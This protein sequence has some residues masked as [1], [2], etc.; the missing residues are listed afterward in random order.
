MSLVPINNNELSFPSLFIIQ[1]F[2]FSDQ[3]RE[4][5]R[6]LRFS[7]LK[8]NDHAII[9]GMIQNIINQL[10][11]QTF[12]QDRTLYLPLSLES[13]LAQPDPLPNRYAV[14]LRSHCALCGSGSARLLGKQ[15]CSQEFAQG[16]SDFVETQESH[17]YF[18]FLR[19]FFKKRKRRGKYSASEA[20]EADS[21]VFN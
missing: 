20:S 5:G 11:Q 19:L 6:H 10:I 1:W 15:V 9:D 14:T 12:H 3:S 16:V 17:T 7:L 4:A 8:R 13:N 18:C 21:V 2:K